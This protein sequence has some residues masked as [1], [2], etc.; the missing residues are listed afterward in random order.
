MP[1]MIMG[2][3][4]LLPFVSEEPGISSGNAEVNTLWP[5]SAAS[6]RVPLI[7]Y[8]PRVASAWCTVTLPIELTPAIRVMLVCSSK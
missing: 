1:A 4:H 2:G 5:C 6:Q 3:R 8:Y 7:D